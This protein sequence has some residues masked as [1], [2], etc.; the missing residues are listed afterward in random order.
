[1]K[2]IWLA[3]VL[4]KRARLRR[5]ERWSR[6]ELEAHQ[7]RALREL[8]DL[9]VARSPFYQRLHRGL[10]TRPLAELPVVTKAMLMEHFDEL[11]VDPQVHRAGVEA[12]LAGLTLGDARY[13]DRYWVVSTSGTSGR[14]GLFLADEE[15]WTTILASY[16]RANDWAGLKAGLAHR[17]K[18]AVVSSRV[19]WHQSARVGK[20]LESPIVR[21]L[22]LD[23]TT[24]LEEITAALDAFAP[25][26][27]V[28]YASMCRVLAE[29]QLAGRLHIAPR[30]VMSA[31]EVLTDESRRHIADAF[32]APPFNVYAATETA[33]IASDCA[34]HRMHLYED[35][36][37]VEAVD[38]KDRPVP[39]GT[40]GARLLVTVLFSRTQP[41]I[42]YEMTDRVALAAPGE[43]CPCGRRFAILAGIEGRTEDVLELPGDRGTVR[44]HPNVFHRVLEPVP[45]A[46]WQV[47]QEPGR[48]RILLESAGP[49][50]D[51]I[52]L[53]A[54]LGAAVVE[55][56]A[57]PLHVTVERVAAIPKTTLGKAPLVR[58]WR[59]S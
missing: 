54:A 1:M 41:L 59:P 29:E 25:E 28:G 4:R 13:L 22:R 31:S 45:A 26:S 6:P 2:A 30:A 37:L 15:E 35:L 57:R 10:E 20:T 27:L 5:Q 52:R 18:V 48:L 39:K 49:D 42:R 34:R 23:A 44:V 55:A 33:G 24:P 47:V 14:R 56:G 46:G 53:A 12:H 8:R 40:F 50:V 38:E 7:A 9:A 58:A 21:T 32:G 43:P 51:P 3:R 19:P 16:A 36:V 11:V 17:L